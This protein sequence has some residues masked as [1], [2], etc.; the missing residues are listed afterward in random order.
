MF[1]DYDKNINVG[2]IFCLSNLKSECFYVLNTDNS[3]ND[4]F[5]VAPLNV[6][7]S[8]GTYNKIEPDICIA[9]DIKDLGLQCI[10]YHATFAFAG[11]NYWHDHNSY[12][13]T[14]LPQY[15]SAYPTI[16]MF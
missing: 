15:G 1:D 11:S 5:T 4:L 6:G 8:D 14:P 7:P 16:N 12:D 10:D 2:D 3:T 9:I 13:N